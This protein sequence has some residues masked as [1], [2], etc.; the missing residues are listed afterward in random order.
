[1]RRTTVRQIALRQTNGKEAVEKAL[2]WKPDLVLLDVRLP[3]LSGFDAARQIKQHKPDIF[4]LF[5]SI[6]DTNE[7]LEDA[8]S[9]GNGFILQ[10]KIKS[11]A[12]VLPN[13]FFWYRSSNECRNA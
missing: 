7:I 13:S 9:A 8:R 11:S 6:H 10:D 2:Q 5:F 1:M 3:V 12:S 4:I